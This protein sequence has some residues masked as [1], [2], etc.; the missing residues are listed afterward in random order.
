MV[1]GLF[2]DL[3]RY[4]AARFSFLLST[5]AIAAAGADAL[6]DLYKSGGLAPDQRGVFLIGIVISAITGGL[7]ISGFMKFLQKF[8]FK[9]F[10]VYRII[11]GII[12]LALATLFRYPAG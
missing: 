12:V 1:A 3:D 5:P 9:F 4:T 10:I 7:V 6:Y 11:F 2:R 8:S